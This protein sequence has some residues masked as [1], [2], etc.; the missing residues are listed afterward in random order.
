MTAIDAGSDNLRQEDV[1]SP[2]QRTLRR[3][4][5]SEHDLEASIPARFEYVSRECA[6]KLA[7][8]SSRHAWTYSE[9]NQIANR[10]AHALLAAIGPDSAPVALLMEHD[11][12]AIASL[13][14][15]LK[16]G[17]FYAFLDP[18][19][20]LPHN[21]GIL[22]D[23][24]ASLLL[25]DRANLPAAMEMTKSGCPLM[26][27][28]A[29]DDAYSLE[30]PRLSVT[31]QMPFA[32]FYTSGSTGQPK[33]VQWS[34][35]LSLRRVLA[36][37]ADMAISQDDRQSLLTSLTF[38][39]SSSDT[40]RALLNGAS[41]HLYDVRKFGTAYLARW[42]QQEE[43]TYLRPPI[44]L[45]RHFVAALDKEDV[46]PSVRA[47]SLGGAA[48]YREDIE[49]AKA[50]FLTSCQIIHRYSTSETGQVARL[51]IRP[52]TKLDSAIVPVGHPISG[53][54]VLILDENRRELHA[55]VGEIAV[56]SRDLAAGYWGQSEQ[57][58]TRFIPDPA[59]PHSVVYLTGDLGRVRHDGCLEFI[60][61][62]DFLVKIRGFRI[63]LAALEAALRKLDTVRDAVVIS[64]PDPAG[65]PSLVAYLVP[66][67]KGVYDPNVLR[68]E[69]A[70][71]LPEYML[72]TTFVFV[73]ALPLT[74]SGKVD[75]KSLSRVKRE[76]PAFERE[77]RA[78]RTSTEARLLTIWSGVLRLDRISVTDNF[79]E[80]GGHSLLAARVIAS[81]NETFHVSLMLR[82]LYEA[83]T[84]AELAVLI[85]ESDSVTV[86]KAPACEAL[87][88]QE[89]RRM[90][91]L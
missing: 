13:L 4:D 74:R 73:D 19:F 86:T 25:C 51:I 29:I 49:N 14:G 12:P 66:V 82:T 7:V 9:L 70:T 88:V 18:S 40:N 87:V 35:H 62:R 52:D 57:S 77:W 16:A 32:I 53:K 55:E 47:I 67:S 64:E 26:V 63:E 43:I 22:A 84:L 80:L 3:L 56:R 90:L 30:N 65:E 23:L 58:P 76:S 24:K 5:L 37:T 34:Q 41:L 31:P 69:L 11:T 46:F 6:D 71:S 20:P 85:E 48:L 44:A 54:Q 1:K 28:D 83:P 38:A 91:G 78:P 15:I 2:A 50:H 21:Q 68:R 61:R 17:K 42:L 72:P 36:D 79:F 45:F 33:G 10:V 89:M 75:R 81:I 27:Y 59:D 8:K 39:G 60:G